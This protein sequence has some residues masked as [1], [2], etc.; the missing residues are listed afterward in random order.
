M[1][2]ADERRVRQLREEIL[3]RFKTELTAGDTETRKS[4]V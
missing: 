1:E 2:E 4:R 3:G